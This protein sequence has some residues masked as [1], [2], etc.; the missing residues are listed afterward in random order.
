MLKKAALLTATLGLLLAPLAGTASAQTAAPTVPTA[1]APA[2]A[3][4]LHSTATDRTNYSSYS[5]GGTV[6]IDQWVSSDGHHYVNGQ[7]YASTGPVSFYYDQSFDGGR[8]WNSFLDREYVYAGG[9]YILPTHYDDGG[10]WYRACS[11][12]ENVGNPYGNPQWGYNIACTSW[13]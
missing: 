4:R 10:V 2:A 1:A 13:Y 8:T 7:L 3:P 9:W 12:N 5:A 6:G 11:A